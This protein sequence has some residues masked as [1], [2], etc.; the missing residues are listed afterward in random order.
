MKTGQTRLEL[1]IDIFEKKEQRA[2][3]L[4]ETKVADVI[5]GILLEFRELEYLGR[6][7]T[8]YQLYREDD[9]QPLD[10]DV[11]LGSQMDGGSDKLDLVE[12][13]VNLPVGA[14]PSPDA[15]YLRE[16]VSG[17]VYPLTWLPAIIGRPDANQPHNDRIAVNLRSY[18]TGLRVSRRHAQIVEEQG[19][20]FIE[21]LSPNPTSIKKVGAE[22]TVPIESKTALEHGDIISLDRSDILLKFIMRLDIPADDILVEM[23][24]DEA[25]D[26]DT[27]DQT[28]DEELES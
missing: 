28:L 5:E 15:I 12:T 4:P 7:A 27:S 24:Q 22:D 9:E 18:A 20:Y 13:E 23:N 21:S 10:P 16:L 1:N 25:F 19:A 8:G 2:L 6:D 11:D 3:I 14:R 17:E 26:A